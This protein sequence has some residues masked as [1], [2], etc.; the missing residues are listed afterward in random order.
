[1]A[2]AQYIEKCFNCG[3]EEADVVEDTKGEIAR[4]SEC[5]HCGHCEVLFRLRGS[6]YDVWHKI[7]TDLRNRPSLKSE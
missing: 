5:P 7:N 6:S 2:T 3:S 1:M 4:D